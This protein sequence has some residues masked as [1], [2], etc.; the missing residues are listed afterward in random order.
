MAVAA[1]VCVPQIRFGLSQSV[2]FPV[3]L[4]LF[5]GC[6]PRNAH[7][8]SEVLSAHLTHIMPLFHSK[9]RVELPLEAAVARGRVT[10]SL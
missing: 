9:E 7:V 10:G 1:I 2:L 5:I 6:P 8:L 3:L 4:S